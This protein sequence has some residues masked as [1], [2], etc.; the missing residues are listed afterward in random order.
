MSSSWMWPASEVEAVETS[1][2]SRTVL[3]TE[4]LDY[5]LEIFNQPHFL[6]NGWLHETGGTEGHRY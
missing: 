4:C 1:L 2:G 5:Q 6:S 3:W